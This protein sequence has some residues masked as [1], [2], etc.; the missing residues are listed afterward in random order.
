M[1]TGPR[2]HER[3]VG[4]GWRRKKRSS[5]RSRW[6]IVANLFKWFETL[7]RERERDKEE[8][9]KEVRESLSTAGGE[10]IPDS[11]K[12]PRVRYYTSRAQVSVVDAKISSIRKDWLLLEGEMRA[13][14]VKKLR[15]IIGRWYTIYQYN[16]SVGGAKNS[17]KTSH[18]SNQITSALKNDRWSRVKADFPFARTN[19]VAKLKNIRSGHQNGLCLRNA[20][21][22]SLRVIRV[23][24]YR[25]I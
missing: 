9:T 16:V 11:D 17:E 24:T 25:T 22:Y 21:T 6:N 13:G 3:H 2:R 19:A 20:T 7:A 8:N 14:R 23:D 1:E 5:W 12:T 4:G 15:R 10:G 18:R